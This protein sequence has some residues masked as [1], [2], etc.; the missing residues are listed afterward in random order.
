MLRQKHTILAV[1][2]T[3]PGTGWHSGG[4]N[5]VVVTPQTR[6]M[7]SLSCLHTAV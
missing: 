4:E 1:A 7:R 2:A 3:S 6:Q 5:R